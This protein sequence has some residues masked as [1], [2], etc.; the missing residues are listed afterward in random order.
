MK[1]PIDIRGLSFVRTVE[2]A[3]EPEAL[4]A[5]TESLRTV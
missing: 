5:D 3:C 2:F 4:H 1:A